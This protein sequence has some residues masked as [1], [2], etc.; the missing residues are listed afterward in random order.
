LTAGREGAK[1]P[2]AMATTNPKDLPRVHEG[3]WTVPKLI[4]LILFTVGTFLCFIY[5][6]SP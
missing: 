4:G 1:S 3:D 6:V 2:D 5:Y